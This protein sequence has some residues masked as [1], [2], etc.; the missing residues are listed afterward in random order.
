[1]ESEE[2]EKE[3]LSFPPVFKMYYVYKDKQAV[4]TTFSFQSYIWSG[5]GT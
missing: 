5:T 4:V 2:Q 3:F 1:M